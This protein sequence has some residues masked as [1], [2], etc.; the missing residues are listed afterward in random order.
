MEQKLLNQRM[1]SYF[2]QRIEEDICDIAFIESELER[3]VQSEEYDKAIAIRE[4]LKVLKC[5]I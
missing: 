3:V 4:A 5:A 1:L 2:Q